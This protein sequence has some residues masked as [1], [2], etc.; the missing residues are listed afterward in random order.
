MLLLLVEKI[1]VVY[2]WFVVLSNVDFV[3]DKGEIVIVVGLNGLGKFILLCV[4]IGVMDVI[5]GCV[6]CKDNLW[7]GY[8]L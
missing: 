7:I 4:L 3:I 6:M 2:G 5:S 1:I 8:V